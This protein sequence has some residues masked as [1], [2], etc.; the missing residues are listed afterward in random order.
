MSTQMNDPAGVPAADRDLSVVDWLL[1]I[2]CGCIGLIMG[3]VY[4]SQGKPKGKKM[5]IIVLVLG[6]IGAVLSIVGQMLAPQPPIG[7]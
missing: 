1:C 3:L 4:V 5:I 2:F 6:A 7:P